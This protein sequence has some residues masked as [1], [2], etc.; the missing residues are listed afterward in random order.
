MNEIDNFGN[1]ENVRPLGTGAEEKVSKIV[2]QLLEIRKCLFQGGTKIKMKNGKVMTCFIDNV[3]LNNGIWYVALTRV[4][5][6]SPTT[7]RRKRTIKVSSVAE[8][9][10][11]SHNLEEDPR[12]FPEVIKPDK[13]ESETESQIESECNSESEPKSEREA[14]LKAEHEE[15]T[16]LGLFY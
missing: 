1:K 14:R 7:A 6:E 16:P 12:V 3:F 9:L 8:I 5:W 15:G 11:S 2:E 10:D 4:K 13:S